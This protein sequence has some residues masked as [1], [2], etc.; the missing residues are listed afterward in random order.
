MG[1]SGAVTKVTDYYLSLHVG[2]CLGPITALRAVWIGEKNVTRFDPISEND[3]LEV[4]EPGLFGGDEQ[5]GGV[6][7]NIEVLL[8]GPDQTM[9]SDLA[10]RLGVT[11]ATCPGFRGLASLFFYGNGDAA[12]GFLWGTNNPYLKA[13]WAQVTAIPLDWYPERAQIGLTTNDKVSIFIG[14]DKSTSMANGATETPSFPSR[15]SVVRDAINASLDLIRLAV[16]SGR[17]VDIKVAFW[18]DSE[19]HSENF[20]ISSPEIDLLQIYVNTRA[21]SGGTNFQTAADSAVDWFNDSLAD[22]EIV[23]R[24]CIIVTDGLGLNGPAAA[25]TMGDLL[26]RAVVGVEIAAGCGGGR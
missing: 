17:K 25:A 13:V 20:D 22:T 9:P 5:E 23:K 19:E 11:T 24:V 18:S 21:L 7:G 4:D 14:V 1:T 26:D 2:I 3:T 12:D 8:G 10:D 16:A 6:A 15:A